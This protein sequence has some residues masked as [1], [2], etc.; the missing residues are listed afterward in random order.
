MIRSRSITH[1]GIAVGAALALAACGSTLTRTAARSAAVDNHGSGISN[2]AAA[3]P[4]QSSQLSSSL[5]LLNE[6]M[7]TTWY[8]VVLTNSGSSSCELSGVPTVTA[9][10]HGISFAAVEA[11]EVSLAGVP[12][13]AQQ[14]NTVRLASGSSASLALG[15]EA[16]GD[17][18]T[19]E[20]VT[21]GVFV[22]GVAAKVSLQLPL[23]C[24]PTMHLQVTPVEA[25]SMT[26]A[27]GFT[28]G[29]A[30]PSQPTPVSA[31]TSVPSFPS[32][33]ATGNTGTAGTS[34]AT[35]TSGTSGVPSHISGITDPS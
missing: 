26:L 10:A 6:D 19:T 4:C 30:A 3:E 11:V 5:H 18:A 20:D 21:L 27:P 12:T 28:T 1:S 13:T 31:P 34:G 25:G 14:V 17:G 24:A 2:A 8:Q 7:S 15:I 16:C 33:G 32:S 9:S 35:S 23:S 22:A 29:G